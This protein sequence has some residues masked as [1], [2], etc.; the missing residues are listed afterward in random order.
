MPALLAGYLSIW[1]VFIPLRLAAKNRGMR[2]LSTVCKMVP[3]LAAAGVAGW[4]CAS[5]ADAGAYARLI[6]AGVA[7]G[8]AADAVIDYR[9][10]AGG[11]LFFL[12][13]G[14]YAAA[15]LTL[16]PPGPITLLLFFVALLL[17]ALYLRRFRS[18]FPTGGLRLGAGAYVAALCA[19]L[20]AALPAPFPLGGGRAILGASGAA[21]FALSDALMVSNAA[22]RAGGGAPAG[23][24]PGMR[25]KRDFRSVLSLGCYYTA[26]AALALSVLAGLNA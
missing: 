4:A 24:G 12:A 19:L 5:G 2:G 17:A 14:L 3:T 23:D 20:A 7:L 1:L 21:L 13:H 15:F 10:A 26:Q 8:A 18:R 16:R 9:L 25:R 22:K 11:C 6:F